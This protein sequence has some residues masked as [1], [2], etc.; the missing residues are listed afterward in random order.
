MCI[1]MEIYGFILMLLLQ[2][3]IKS[4]SMNYIQFTN[5]FSMSLIGKK[6]NTQIVMKVSNT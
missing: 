1:V 2:I 3:P 6:S 5:T 4:N